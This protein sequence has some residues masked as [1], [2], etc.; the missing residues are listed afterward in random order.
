MPEPER[1]TADPVVVRE[2]VDGAHRRQRVVLV[3][4]DLVCGLTC[5][6]NKHETEK[7]SKDGRAGGGGGCQAVATTL[8]ALVGG[9]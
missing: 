3:V 5:T 6:R 7:Q 9:S 8:L 4:D 1:P 2:L